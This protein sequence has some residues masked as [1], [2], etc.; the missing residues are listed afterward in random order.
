MKNNFNLKRI[1][2]LLTR[3]IFLKFLYKFKYKLSKTI[4]EKK[5][6]NFLYTLRPYRSNNSLIRL[7]EESDGGYLIPNDL[8]DIKGCFT[9]GVGDKAK[10]ELDLAD[11]G[12]TCFMADYSVTGPPISHK[13]FNFIKK[14]IKNENGNYSINIDEWINKNKHLSYDYI[15]KIDIEGDEYSVLT[16]ISKKNLLQM[17]IIIFEIHE[18]TDVLNPKGFILTNNLFKKL[19]ESHTIVHINPNNNSPS[20]KFSKKLE[21]YDCMEITM[22]RNDRILQKEPEDNFP[23]KLDH[24]FNNFFKSKLPKCFYKKSNEI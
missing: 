10:F 1:F 21:L 7:G 6:L 9:A 18:F 20:I 24:K 8:E 14:F 3:Q 12:I 23:H 4:S 16:N 13:N 11:K 22:L 5:L 17:R 15:L 19:L 2:Y